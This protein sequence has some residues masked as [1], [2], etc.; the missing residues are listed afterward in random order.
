MTHWPTCGGMV[1]HRVTWE[2]KQGVQITVVVFRFRVWGLGFRVSKPKTLFP[3]NTFNTAS[4]VLRA[5]A[6]SEYIQGLEGEDR[7]FARRFWWCQGECT[8]WLLG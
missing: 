4:N 1:L 3:S 7:F 8:C 6:N 5:L 2:N